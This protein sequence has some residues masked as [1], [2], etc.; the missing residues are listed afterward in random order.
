[1]RESFRLFT[2]LRDKVA[3]IAGLLDST[4]YPKRHSTLDAAAG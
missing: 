4:S 3:S 1:M 2:L